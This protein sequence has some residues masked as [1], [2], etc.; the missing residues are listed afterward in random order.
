VD[1]I[2]VIELI[3]E[4]E[5]IFLRRICGQ[6]VLHGMKPAGLGAA[7]LV[8][9]IDLAGWVFTDVVMDS[10]S[11]SALALPSIRFAVIGNI[12]CV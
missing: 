9:N 5:H 12:P 7:L 2:V 4:L 6:R 8:A 3:D 10:A 11:C 1:G